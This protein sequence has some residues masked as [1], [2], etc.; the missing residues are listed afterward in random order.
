MNDNYELSLLKKLVSINSQTGNIEGYREITNVIIN[1]INSLGMEIR[2]YDGNNEAKDGIY[3]PNIVAHYNVGA[4]KTLGLLT[5]FDTVPPGTSWHVDPF[6]AEIKE[7]DGEER[8]F[9]RGAAD[10]KGCI[11]AALGA[12]RRIIKK[13]IRSRWNITFMCVADEE[14][15][16][17]YGAGYIARNR[18]VSLDALIVLD[19]SSL[20]LV[21]GTSGIVHGVIKIK[22]KQGHAGYILGSQNALHRA[23]IFLREM[24]DFIDSRSLKISKLKNPGSMPIPN[25]WGRFS[26]TWIKTSNTTFN[27]IPGDVEV[28]FDMRL[29]PEEEPKDA[30]AELKAFFEMMKYKTSIY[31]VELDIIRTH[32]GYYTDE[33]HPFVRIA[34]DALYEATGRTLP[35]IGML[36]G[37]DGGWFRD[38]NIPIISFGVWDEKSNIH[39][40]DESVSLRKIYEL[41]EFIVNLIQKP[42]P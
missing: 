21:V 26:L 20:G 1:E 37:N 27:V 34:R 17:H 40:E 25:I 16:G 10:D 18:F 5:H 35:I 14:I 4:D 29:I 33:K 11:V 7:V 9:G 15:G 19:S 32:A 3:R 8:V 22:G 6:G 38:Y 23:V 2:I 31:D 12:L 36:G 24:L 42:P 39:G 41:E 13:N 30:V 28:G